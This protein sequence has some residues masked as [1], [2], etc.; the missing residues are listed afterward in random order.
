MQRRRHKD[1]SAK[2]PAK[3]KHVHVA[4][5][6]GKYKAKEPRGAT[7]LSK[8]ELVLICCA[9]FAS[10][11]YSAGTCTIADCDESMNYWEP[12]HFLTSGGRGL[13]TWEYS[14]K[15]ALRSYAYIGLHAVVGRA[16]SFV[17]HIIFTGAGEGFHELVMFFSI[18]GFLGIICGIVE[19][20]FI[21]QVSRVFG[22][23]VGAATAVFCVFS[24]ALHISS[25][26]FLPSSFSMICIMCAYAAWLATE[27]R[28]GSGTSLWT[29][30]CISMFSFAVILGWP[31]AAVL[32]VPVAF[33]ML[34]TQSF[35]KLI[36]C[37]VFAFGVTLGVVVAVDFHFYHKLVIAP[38]NILLYNVFSKS[39]SSELYGV[40]PVY[41]YLFNGCLN[42]NVAFLLALPGPFIAA[43]L[44]LLGTRRASQFVSVVATIPLWIWLAIM[45]VQPHKEER[46]LSVVYPFVCLCG[47]ITLV[48]IAKVLRSIIRHVTSSSILISMYYIMVFVPFVLLSVSRIINLHNSY[49]APMELYK[50]LSL[51]ELKGG[52]DMTYPISGDVNICV[53]KEWYRFYS[54]FFLPGDRFHIR[55]VKSNFTGQLP[56]PYGA[57]TWDIPDHMNDLNLEEPTRYT[58]LTQC[59]YLVDMTFPGQSEPDYAGDAENWKVVKQWLFLDAPHSPNP[60]LRSFWVSWSI[61]GIK[62]S[63]NQYSLLK[64]KNLL[65]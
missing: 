19:V 54:N 45:T 22:R 65:P 23:A 28:N 3:T 35:F 46:F 39:T 5:D 52:R 17:S 40:E 34:V 44:P 42:F 36:L 14:G 6:D 63:W 62:N 30:I 43:L 10:T 25:T 59:H 27:N 55:F 11:L 1:T 53:G 33:R 8:L 29:F 13:Q 61:N 51:E 48:A 50:Y 49:G 4:N 12:T 31:F 64:N 21:T 7:G 15:Y 9:V 20:A 16:A 38:L 18:R 2:T 57:N 37:S 47:S 32:A 24:P 26:A 41:F 58:P 56:Q 60:L